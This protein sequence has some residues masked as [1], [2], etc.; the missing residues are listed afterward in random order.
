MHVVFKWAFRLAATGVILVGILVAVLLTAFLSTLPDH[1][2]AISISQLSDEV[3]LSRNIN[4]IPYIVASTH[5]DSAR[6][7]GF[8]HAQDRFWQMHVLRMVGQGRLSELFGRPTIDT[9]IFLRT[10]DIG[11][12]S[13]RSYD[14][15]SSKIRSLMVAYSEGVNSWL[16]RDTGFLQ[17]RLPPEFVILGKNAERWEPW[18]SLSILKVMALTLD[19]NLRQEIQRLLLTSKKF[20]PREIEELLPYGPRDNPPPLPD[21]RPVY[22]YGTLSGLPAQHAV[23][24]S[25]QDESGELAWETG[26]TASN[27]WV[28]SGSRSSTGKPLLAN[29]PHLE[30]TAPSV[31]YLAHLSFKEGEGEQ[32]MTRTLVGATLPGA[33]IIIAGRNDHLAWGLTT[34]VLDSQD[35]YIE[36]L[37]GDD[38]DQYL[39]PQGWKPFEKTQITIEVAG[40]PP[41][42]F[43]RRETRHGPVLPDNYRNI[44]AM[45]PTGHVGS[46][47]WTAL[48]SDDTT[49]EGAINMNLSR[50][51]GEFID[52]T[53]KMVSPMQS[54][55]VADEE[56]DIA[57]IA[58]GRAPIRDPAN[59]IAGRAPVP[60]WRELY[61]WKGWIDHADIPRIINP[62]EGAI[63]TANANWLPEG[64]DEHITYDWDEHYRQA[65]VEE[66]IVEGDEI[67]T[68]EDMKTV[69][70]D[71]YS[72]ALMEFRRVATS[73]LAA[74]ASQDREM[75]DAL[76]Q[77]D[78]QMVIDSPLPLIMTAWWRHTAEALFQDD[79]GKDHDRFSRGKIRPVLDA[80]TIS[81]T[82]DW[83][84]NRLTNQVETCSIIL[85]RG[86]SAAN[87]ELR[88]KFGDDW[89]QW[90]W[91]AAH[92]AIGTHRPFSSIM[93][94]ANLF[95]ISPE[96]AGDSYTLLRGRTD[97]RNDNPYANGHASAFR[98]IY[99]LADLQRSQYMISTG[100]SGHFLSAH[101]RDL[102]DDWADMRYVEIVQIPE[103][104]DELEV[105]TL[106]PGPAKKL[107]MDEWIAN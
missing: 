73:Q 21:L 24:N 1:S 20:S 94:L 76:R 53:R 6:A 51:V 50:S 23:D 19:G 30:L 47:Q 75:L 104:D 12:A 102:A 13:E 42:R 81:G 83:C 35:L 89:R 27:N 88:Q 22:G 55:V 77:W 84:D 11:G 59:L 106:T 107:W 48:A 8:A 37:K 10:I 41:V 56:G 17:A 70:S 5:E 60:G 80:L 31:F 28:V 45:M 43:T 39:T 33:P 52:A 16:E 93:P 61:D 96:S 90:R 62:G 66:L 32:Q 103:T 58:P 9:D 3:K 95:S 49:A 68:L 7:L 101:Y 18:H 63:A 91:G 40:A 36:R 105:I 26:V 4:G 99:D 86:L 34:T 71:V 14:V 46:L 98:G 65:R 100:Q 85:A 69:Q 79:L 87:E 29:D 54:I 74:G 97:F 82:R 44:D 92:T 78:G 64:Y 2:G 72:P 38:P 67:H 25:R 57:V 15:L